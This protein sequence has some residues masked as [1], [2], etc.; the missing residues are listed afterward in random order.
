MLSC[1]VRPSVRRVSVTFFHCVER[2]KH[3]VKFFR[4]WVVFL[5][6]TLWQHGP[7]DEDDEGV[8]CVMTKSQFLTIILLTGG[9]WSVVKKFQV[10]IMITYTSRRSC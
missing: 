10:W 4:C 7:P 6:Q 8:E 5:Y 3:T 1:G 9:V 2:S